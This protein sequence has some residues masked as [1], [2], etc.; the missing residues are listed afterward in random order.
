MD[1]KST[2]V[3]FAEFDWDNVIAC[4]YKNIVE[5]SELPK[6]PEVRRDLALLLNKETSYLQVKEV[7]MQTEKKLLREVN[8]FDVYQGEKLESEK[9]SYAV[10]LL[11]QN[12]DAT[13]N[14]KQIEAV[15]NKIIRNLEEKLDA[16]IR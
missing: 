11:L 7:I 10:S 2:A 5:F 12:E 1:I 13:L 16:K 3:F 14:D 9:K 8:L 15:M 4:A 6:F